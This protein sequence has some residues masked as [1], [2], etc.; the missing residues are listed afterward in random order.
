M[1]A[2]AVS[3]LVAASLLTARGES[4]AAF[5]ER[6]IRAGG[7]APPSNIG[8]ILSRRAWPP[9]RLARLGATRDFH[10]GLLTH[11]PIQT[12]A[13]GQA[14]PTSDPVRSV[15]VHHLHFRV[16]DPAAAMQAYADRLS[17]TRVLLQGLGV[18]VRIGGH[19]LLFE[20]EREESAQNP[21]AADPAAAYRAAVPWLASHGVAV[22]AGDF[23][24]IPISAL[25]GAGP[26]DHLAF[27]SGDYQR[28]VDL[29]GA[30]GARPVSRTDAAALFRMA[31]GS[32]IEIVRDTD[33]P[34]A[35]WCPMHPGIRSGTI[36]SCPICAMALVPMP[37]PRI[38]EY[39]MDVAV[40][41]GA[42]GRGLGG[43]R[44]TIREPGSGAAVPSFAVMHERL[45][46]LF[47]VSR[48]LQYFA[49]VHPEP[50]GDGVFRL[51]H[52][53][54]PGEYV[55][56][57]DFLPQT[58]TAQMVH[59][60]IVT[61][62]HRG[63]LFTETPPLISDL[64]TAPASGVVAAGRTTARWS[65]AEKVVDGVRVR[66][67][68][69]DIIAGKRGILRFRL[70]EA[71]GGAP[72][73]DLEPFLGAPGHLLMVNPALTDAVH[74]HPEETDA[75]ESFVTFIPL[76]PAAGAFKV[77]AQFQR[78]GKVITVPFVIVATEP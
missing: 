72:I 65:A 2:V 5:D 12:P 6:S 38:G 39:R 62:G 46:H 20:R 45:L 16:G 57:A 24:S 27:V 33:A 14:L 13:S 63:S 37:P 55:V 54:P 52:P 9:R 17:G 15:R 35:F 36:G 48:D 8:H 78:R 76:V 3:G 53:A 34:D 11:A 69:A 29:I 31:D 77:W 26:L 75:R 50:A 41:P 56:I 47:L 67:D 60:A 42:G 30:A 70:F 32:R 64:S 22:Q 74:V 66:L 40:T 4:P 49:H 23:A 51:T 43:L 7:V 10:H 61:P 25:N 21:V 1:R 73:T 59:R 44:I 18:G 71:N 28:T 19:Y 68:A 58:G